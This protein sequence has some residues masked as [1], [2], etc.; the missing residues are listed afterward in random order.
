MKYLIPAL[1]VLIGFSQCQRRDAEPQYE[2]KVLYSG[3]SVRYN[4]DSL[5]AS[6]PVFPTKYSDYY[7]L[8]R[9]YTNNTMTIDLTHIL[10]HG[11]SETFR[12]FV[13]Y[14]EDGTTDFK[15]WYKRRITNGYIIPA[16]KDVSIYHSIPY[17]E[18]KDPTF[19]QD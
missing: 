5:P 2:T 19:Q 6:M 15:G 4:I 11:M 17:N 12:G 13:R 10:K 7:I 9:V 14:K 16:N 3:D 18:D 1:I 8:V